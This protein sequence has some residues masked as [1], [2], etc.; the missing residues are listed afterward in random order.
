MTIQQWIIVI[1]ESERRFPRP[2]AEDL[3]AGFCKG[4]ASVGA[5]LFG[6]LELGFE[7]TR[8]LKRDES[9]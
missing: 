9:R 3:A 8:R 1:Y 5:S 4:A 2:Q 6:L 7:L